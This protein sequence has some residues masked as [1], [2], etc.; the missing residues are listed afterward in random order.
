MK[1]TMTSIRKFTLLYLFVYCYL[2]PNRDN[3]NNKAVVN[4]TVLDFIAIKHGGSSMK[5]GLL[6]SLARYK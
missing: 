5:I 4:T 1:N 2:S 6:C 3:N